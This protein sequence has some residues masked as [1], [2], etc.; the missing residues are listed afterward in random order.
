MEH[1][2]VNA[3]GTGD[4]CVTQHLVLRCHT[5]QSSLE[6]K[7]EKLIYSHFTNGAIEAQRHEMTWP[8]VTS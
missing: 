2:N 8:K 1:Q 4:I 5:A 3:R 7:A 6:K